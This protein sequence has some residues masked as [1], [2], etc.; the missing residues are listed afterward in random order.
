M[1]RTNILVLFEGLDTDGTG[2]PRVWGRGTTRLVLPR[3]ADWLAK[4]H[5]LIY[6]G[7]H[8]AISKL[9]S[10]SFLASM[11]SR[12]LLRGQSQS[13]S[14]SGHRLPVI[15]A[16]HLTGGR[17]NSKAMAVEPVDLTGT[18]LHITIDKTVDVV[19]DDLRDLSSQHSSGN[20]K[21]PV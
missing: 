18:R 6:L 13:Q 8:F 10:N 11:N 4:P 21:T 20:T 3:N 16:H 17:H 14:T 9:Y 2:P 5:A 1:A 19:E 15:F 7:F 12:K